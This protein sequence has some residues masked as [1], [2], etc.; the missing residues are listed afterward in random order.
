MRKRGGSSPSRGTKSLSL[1]A[2]IIEADLIGR[3]FL[4][5]RLDLVP[6]ARDSRSANRLRGLPPSMLR[7]KTVPRT[8]LPRAQPRGASSSLGSLRVLAPCFACRC[9]FWLPL[10]GLAFA[11]ISLRSL[12]ALIDF[13]FAL[14][15]S[16]EYQGYGSGSCC[17][18]TAGR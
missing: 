5:V 16:R 8:V 2:R 15:A 9:F 1:Q 3:L 12:V 10:R 6:P 13:S 11:S 14:L 7:T 17:S 18:V 4:F